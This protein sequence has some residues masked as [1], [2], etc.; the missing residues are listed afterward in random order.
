MGAKRNAYLTEWQVA[1]SNGAT[2]TFNNR[3]SVDD[4]LAEIKEST[5]GNFARIF[6]TTLYGYEVM[7][8]ALENCSTATT[9]YLASV[10]DWSVLAPVWHR[11]PRQQP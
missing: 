2:T 3:A 5:G 7:V 9:K 6:D 11:Q 4:Q 8:K 1:M 10:D